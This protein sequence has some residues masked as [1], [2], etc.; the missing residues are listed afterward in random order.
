MKIPPSWPLEIQREGQVEEVHQFAPTG[1][2]APLLGR[3]FFHGVLDCYTLVRD[4]YSREAGIELPDFERADDWWN[5]GQ[6][7]YMEQ[8][9][10][11]GFSRIPDAAQILPGDVILMA[12]RS[13]VANPN[14][15][16]ADRASMPGSIPWGAGYS[17]GFWSVASAMLAIASWSTPPESASRWRSASSPFSAWRC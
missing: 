17:P 8:F 15:A 6:D 16:L 3:Q 10:Q 9:A 12:V 13:P 11:A 1:W 2:Q 4:W 5:Q 7:L 14:P